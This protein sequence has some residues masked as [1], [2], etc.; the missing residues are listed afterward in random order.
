MMDAPSRLTVPTLDNLPAEI[1]ACYS[2]D[3][4]GGYRLKLDDEA[5]LLAA[6]KR[7][8]ESRKLAEQS[9]KDAS[10]IVNEQE[11]AFRHRLA[12]VEAERDAAQRIAAAMRSRTL[13]TTIRER[14]KAS[15][16]HDAAVA[17]AFRAARELFDVDAAGEIVAKDGKATIDRFFEA[18]KEASPHWYPMTGSGGGAAH[19]SG[20]GGSNYVM[21]RHSF[22]G[23]PPAQRAALLRDGNVRITD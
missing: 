9:A 20:Q 12:K 18:A 10:A 21:N 1:A 6:L 22:D 14:A 3:E 16:M 17:D 7:E 4:A 13:E 15:G 5:G 19:A 8:R 11:A 2:P 23:L